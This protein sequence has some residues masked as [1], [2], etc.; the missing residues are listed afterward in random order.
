MR[1]A[2]SQVRARTLPESVLT[3]FSLLT[4]QDYKKMRKA[5][6]N[7]LIKI[8]FIQNRTRMTWI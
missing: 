4:V 5:C 2:T 8:N 6:D 1:N 7:D 3:I